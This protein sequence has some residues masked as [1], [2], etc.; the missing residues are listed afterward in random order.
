MTYTMQVSI[1][2]KEGM[3]I[4]SKQMTDLGYD[5]VEWGDC[6]TT[7]VCKLMTMIGALTARV[8]N[9]EMQEVGAVDTKVEIEMDFC[10]Q[11]IAKYMRSNPTPPPTQEYLDAIRAEHYER[12]DGSGNG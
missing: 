10:P 1:T 6:H 2:P 3:D 9:L 4:V 12:M 5:S 11:S 8:R 7:V